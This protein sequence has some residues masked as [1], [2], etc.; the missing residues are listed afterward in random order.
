MV[1]AIN[2]AKKYNQADWK[3]YHTLHFVWSARQNRQKTAGVVWYANVWKKWVF[4]FIAALIVAF[5]QITKSWIRTNLLPG[6]SLPETWHISIIH[7]Q[8]TGAAF[9]L[10]TNQSFILTIVAVI[11]LLV[12]LFFYRYISQANIASNFALGLIL[13][14]AL[15]NLVDRIRIGYVTDFIYVRLWND[16]YWP[17]FNIADASITIGVFLLAFLLI[18]GIKEDNAVT[19]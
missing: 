13:G 11:G 10:F 7:A 6:E 15:G 8:N 9:G 17:A 12:I 16:V 18:K 5:D 19:C 2:A 3:R 14:G 1:S 4:L